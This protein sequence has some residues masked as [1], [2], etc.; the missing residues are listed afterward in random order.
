MEAQTSQLGQMAI[1]G[2]HVVAVSGL[3]FFLRRLH[4]GKRRQS[5]ASLMRLADNADMARRNIQRIEEEQ[6]HARLNSQLRIKRHQPFLSQDQLGS[7]A[8]IDRF[9]ESRLTR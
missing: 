4:S 9:Q 7:L 6:W 2:L 5:R 1:V 8:A 3:L